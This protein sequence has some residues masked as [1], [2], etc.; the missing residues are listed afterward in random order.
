MSALCWYCPQTVVSPRKMLFHVVEQR[1]WLR[2]VLYGLQKDAA[3]LQ[4]DR[5]GQALLITA[6]QLPP[7]SDPSH[8]EIN[9]N[10]V[11]LKH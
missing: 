3:M 1:T 6:G 5:H 4:G 7:C 11:F 10:Q 2:A 8:S 9:Q